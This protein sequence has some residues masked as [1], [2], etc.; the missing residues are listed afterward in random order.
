[1]VRPVDAGRVHRVAPSRDVRATPSPLA[2]EGTTMTIVDGG[3][4]AT[5]EIDT[6][7][8]VHVASALDP[9]GGLLGVESFKAD[10]AGYRKLLAWMSFVGPVVHVGVEGT[11]A[12]GAGLSR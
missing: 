10:P 9:I 7:L 8:D 6:H 2:K 11:G 3:R 1:M 5:G 4:P 12:Y